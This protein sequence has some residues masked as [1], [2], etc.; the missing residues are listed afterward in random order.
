MQIDR[1]GI[2]LI[3]LAALWLAGQVLFQLGYNA[4]VANLLQ[5]VAFLAVLLLHVNAVTRRPAGRDPN[6]PERRI[7]PFALDTQELAA[8]PDGKPYG[9]RESDDRSVAQRIKAAA[10]AG[11]YQEPE[12][13]KALKTEQEEP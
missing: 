8:L 1:L 7:D 12:W 10:R 3:P 4:E 6:A 11:E 13:V 5:M 2:L 9:R